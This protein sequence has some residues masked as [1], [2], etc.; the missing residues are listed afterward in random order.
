MTI[1][2]ECVFI[3]MLFPYIFAALAKSGKNYDNHNPRGYLEKVTGWRKRA[4]FVQLNSFE[5]LPVFGMAVIIAHL[6]HASQSMLDKL[7]I[8]FVVSR[9]LYAIC[10]LSDKAGLRTLCWIVGMGCVVGIFCITI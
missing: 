3:M 5:S 4:H 10:Y 9:L 8:I 7:A 1:A 2:Y 6:A